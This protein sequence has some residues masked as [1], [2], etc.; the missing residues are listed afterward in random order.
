MSVCY[1]IWTHKNEKRHSSIMMG[2]LREGSQFILQI[3]GILS[4]PLNMALVFISFSRLGIHL[5]SES[6]H[7]HESCHSF[8]SFKRMHCPMSHCVFVWSSHA[9]KSFV[10][11][12]DVRREVEEVLPLQSKQSLCQYFWVSLMVTS[13]T[14]FQNYVPSFVSSMWDSSWPSFDETIPVD[15]SSSSRK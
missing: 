1:P 7:F 4:S 8:E 11:P 2:K 5:V 6:I 12:L 15:I 14:S 13:F 3:N 9:A 10:M